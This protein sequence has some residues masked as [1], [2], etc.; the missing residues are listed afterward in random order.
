M[1]K[2]YSNL[3]QLIGKTPLL[4]LGR[5]SKEKGAKA[6]ILAKLECF[7]PGG[8]VKDRTALGMIEDAEEKALLKKGGVIIEPTS[9]NTGIGLAWISRVKGYR[10]IVVMP[11]SMSKERQSLLK[12]FGAEVELTPGSL[13][14]SGSIQRAN[15]LKKEIVGAVILGQF[16]NPANPAIHQKTTAQE[17]W[18]DTSGKVD[19]FIASVGTGGTLVGVAKALKAHNPQ[20]KIIAVE[21]KKS[22]VLS[23]GQM[24]AHKI[25]GIGAG[26]IPSIFD[27]SVVDE[28]IQ[29]EDDDAFLLAREVAFYEGLLVGISSGAALWAAFHIA[30]E[31]S[32]K[33]KKIVVLL[34]DTGERYLS[35]DLFEED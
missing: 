26:F 16:D 17:I 27:E 33:D 13:G 18:Q 34:P 32:Y 15:E 9:G 29:V 7:N 22:P 11:D 4:E 5:L 8:S 30:K 24:G 35:C 12:A 20:I 19:V 31:D 23:G 10:T 2:I 3:I 21:P 6:Q 25:Q 1:S 14:M 28:I